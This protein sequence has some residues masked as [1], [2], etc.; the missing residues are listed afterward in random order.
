M[1]TPTLSVERADVPVANTE[2]SV[3]PDEVADAWAAVIIDI[4]EKRCKETEAE[5]VERRAAG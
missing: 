3:L 2:P 4:Y 1:A 5:N